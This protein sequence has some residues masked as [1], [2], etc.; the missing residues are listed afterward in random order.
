MRISISRKKKKKKSYISTTAPL[1]ASEVITG[2]KGEERLSW[3]VT[4]LKRSHGDKLGDGQRHR[5]FWQ[6]VKISM[7][8]IKKCT[9]GEMFCEPLIH[10]ELL[11]LHRQKHFPCMCHHRQ[12]LRNL[13]STKPACAIGPYERKENTTE[14]RPWKIQRLSIINEEEAKYPP[15]SYSWL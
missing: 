11:L 4:D 7:Q 6:G 3:E 5:T 8:I 2:K 12:L 9:W 15:R 13:R 1:A 14:H 10:C